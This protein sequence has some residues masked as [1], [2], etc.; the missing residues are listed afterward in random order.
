MEAVPRSGDSDEP[1]AEPPKKKKR[2]SF[3]DGVD[4]GSNGASADSEQSFIQNSN[5]LLT[6]I[7]ECLK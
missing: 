4:N 3:S 5:D 6:R 1:A 2:V 7:R